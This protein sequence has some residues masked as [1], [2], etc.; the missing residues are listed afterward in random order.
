MGARLGPLLRGLSGR[1][2]TIEALPNVVQ[3]A[4]RPGWSGDLVLRPGPAVGDMSRR[5][6]AGAG[7]TKQ[8]SLGRSLRPT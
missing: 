1:V 4:C 7:I 8:L 3:G 6:C 5:G 2:E